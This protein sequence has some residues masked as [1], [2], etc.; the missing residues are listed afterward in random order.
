MARRSAR[1]TSCASVISAAASGGV[2]QPHGQGLP[3][4]D[5]QQPGLQRDA[6]AGDLLGEAGD[7]GEAAGEAGVAAGLPH[8]QPGGGGQQVRG[9]AGSGG[10]D[11]RG[12]ELAEV[13][14]EHPAQLGGGVGEQ[15]DPR[16]FQPGRGGGAA[17]GGQGVEQ[18]ETGDVDDRLHRHLDHPPART[19]VRSM[20]EGSDSSAP[21]DEVVDNRACGQRLATSPVR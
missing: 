9:A 15:R 2:L 6:A 21:A 8:R 3:G 20:P 19:C 16:R 13:A 7:G 1:S 10:G 18:R 4:A 11:G 12:V 14:Q 5:Q 17:D